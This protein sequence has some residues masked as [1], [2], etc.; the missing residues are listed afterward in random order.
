MRE[1]SHFDGHQTTG[2]NLHKNITKCGLW[3]E[4]SHACH[5]VGF[6]G[7]YWDGPHKRWYVDGLSIRGGVGFAGDDRPSPELLPRVRF[8][9][10]TRTNGLEV[11]KDGG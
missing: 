3:I 5:R 11:S 7:R 10:P 8:R 9:C 2:Y 6:P 4:L 1:S